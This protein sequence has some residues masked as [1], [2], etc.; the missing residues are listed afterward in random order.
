MTT[1][2]GFGVRG[3]LPGQGPARR[4]RCSARPPGQ[5]EPVA[6]SAIRSAGAGVAIPAWF[7]KDRPCGAGV[8]AVGEHPAVLLRGGQLGAAASSAWY[9]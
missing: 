5:P 6:R 7:G 1:R 2:T 3:P 4:A 8:G 9:L